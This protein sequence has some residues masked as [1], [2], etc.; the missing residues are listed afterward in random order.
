MPRF[1]NTGT[2]YSNK[3]GNVDLLSRVQLD[4]SNSMETDDANHIYTQEK[5]IAK[6]EYEK[7]QEHGSSLLSPLNNNNIE[8]EKTDGYVSPFSDEYDRRE[9]V[10]K[11]EEEEE[12]ERVAT[13]R[14]QFYGLCFLIFYIFALGVGYHYTTFVDGT[15]SLVTLEQ[16]DEDE[17]LAKTN[18]YI[19]TLQNLH[20]EAFEVTESFT[21]ETIG[22]NELLDR[23]K[24]NEEKTQKMQEEIKDIKVPSGYESY[25]SQLLELYSLHNAFNTSLENYARSRSESSFNLVNS[26]NEKYEDKMTDFLSLLDKKFFHN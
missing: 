26:A 18:E 6:G 10:M 4:D 9:E 13:N 23:T 16:R 14:F 15:P 21:A 1:Q 11:E 2:D 3:Q 7:K 25:H 19:L 20:T 12:D 22:T 24:K 5:G 17:Y 8:Q